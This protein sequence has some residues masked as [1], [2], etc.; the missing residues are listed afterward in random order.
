MTDSPL[1]LLC[2][3]FC[4]A[5]AVI[6]SAGV[7]VG[8]MTKTYRITRSDGDHP[9]ADNRFTRADSPQPRRLA[10]QGNKGEGV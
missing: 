7:F 5:P 6:F 9:V 8:R 2:G 3:L 1:A 4:L 10:R